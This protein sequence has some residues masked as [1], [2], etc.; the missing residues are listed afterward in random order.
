M[1]I[2]TWRWRKNDD[3]AYG[4]GPG[5]DSFVS[6]G[7][8][9]QIGR[10]NLITAQKS[11]EPPLVAY[12]DLR[13][14]IQRGPNSITYMKSNHGDLR[15]RM[16]QPLMTGVQ[17]LPF[18]VEYQDR[19]RQIINEHFHTDVFMMMSSLAK[20]K[21]TSRMV[22]EQVMELQGEKAAILGTRVGN[23]Q[24]E[25]FNPL[26]DRVYSIEAAAGR[27]PTPPD[28][29]LETVHGPVEVQYLG[30]LAQAQTR[31]TTVRST[32]SFLQVAKQLAEMDP[33]VIHFINAPYMLRNLRDALNAPVDA[34]YDEKTCAGIVQ[35][36]NKM[37]EQQRQVENAPKLAKAAAAMSKAPEAGSA[38]KQ[39]V[40][41]G[42]ATTESVD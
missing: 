4:R 5:H 24:S 3:E 1:P 32:Q 23:L 38:L 31:L 7:L 6:I 16:P 11:A 35:N 14:A 29:L 22:V 28:I 41:G 34:V 36:L 37:A 19:V 42:A 2:I 13:G 18:N 33:T 9:N 21:D 26:I 30:P 39:L 25:F 40:S 17:G 15:S 12:S 8:A 27:I 10:T 20:G